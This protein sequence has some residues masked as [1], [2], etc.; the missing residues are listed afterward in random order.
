MSDVSLWIA[1]RLKDNGFIIFD[2]SNPFVFSPES[3]KNYLNEI[4]KALKSK[5][6]VK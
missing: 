6:V 4:D 5:R 2:E 3:Y 1:E